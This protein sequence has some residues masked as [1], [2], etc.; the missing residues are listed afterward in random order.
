MRYHF[1]FFPLQCSPQQLKW[2]GTRFKRRQNVSFELARWNP[3]P[4]RL[5]A[6]GV[7]DVFS[8]HFG[9]SVLPET[10]ITARR[11]FIHSFLIIFFFHF[12]TS[13]HLLQ[14][15][16]R[17][18]T[19]CRAHVPTSDRLCTDF[20]FFFL[21]LFKSLLDLGGFHTLGLHWPSS[22][23]PVNV[24]FNLPIY[25]SRWGECCNTVLLWSSRN[26]SWTSNLPLTLH[27]APWGRAGKDWI[28][29]LG[30]IYP[31]STVCS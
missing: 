6:G 23:E 11:L 31:L 3:E 26:V 17:K 2:M 16:R 14:L 27:P 4:L 13:P 28:S 25:F 10:W 12:K 18:A 5:H 21:C 24:H 8:N 29:T 19:C 7:N 9:I 1:R 20:Y 15:L 22:K 30:W